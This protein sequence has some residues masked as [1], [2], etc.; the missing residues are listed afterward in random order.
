MKIFQSL[1]TLL[2]EMR[3]KYLFIYGDNFRNRFGFHRASYYLVQ[4][5]HE[6]TVKGRHLD[7][8]YYA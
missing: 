2:H 6:N 4:I 5:F 7:K 1:A 3:I 8:L